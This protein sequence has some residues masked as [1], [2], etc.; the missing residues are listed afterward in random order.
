MNIENI[1]LNNLVFNENFTRKVIPF[2]KTEYFSNSDAIVYDLLNEYINKYNKLPTKEALLID[3]SQKKGISQEIV[4]QCSDTIKSFTKTVDSSTDWLL[5][6]TENFCKDKS[7]YNAVFESIEILGNKHKNKTKGAIPQLLSDA[8]AVSFDTNIG[9]D[10]LEDAKKRFDYYHKV[11]DRLSFD[12]EYLNQITNGG[13]PKKTLTVFLAGVNVGKSQLMCHMAA[14]NLRQGKNVLYISLEMSEEEISKR[15]DANLLDINMDE[16]S[17]IPEDVFMK[18]I[19]RLK[20]KTVGK[21]L[22]KEYPTSQ[23]GAANFRYL[24][25][26]CKIKKNFFPD[27]I[28]IDYINICCS[29]RIKRGQANSYEYIKAI[30]EELRGFAV[31][32]NVPLVTA[33]QLTRSGYTSS[34]VGLEDTAESFGLPATADFMAALITTEELEDMGQ[35]MVKQLKNRLGNKNTNKRFIIGVDRAKMRFY[36]V[37][38]SAQD[39]L[40]DGPVMDKTE[41]GREDNERKK[42]GKK[43]DKSLFEGFK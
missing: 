36:D 13:L 32:M 39:N 16:L 35:I 37:E 20:E 10:Y 33:T 7:I 5:D 43:F 15:V 41:F 25:N 40:M 1:I 18:K 9:H 8:L 2:L 34:D 4:T 30:A 27:I 11:V 22:V 29:S 24:V 26:E 38:Q 28:Y 3:L 21:L 6:Q 42:K 17:T 12:I 31:E 23:A 19:N 14:H